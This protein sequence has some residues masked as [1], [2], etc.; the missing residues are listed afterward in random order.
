MRADLTIIQVKA[1]V[2]HFGDAFE[3]DERALLDAIEGE[4]DA[5][6]LVSKVLRQCEADLGTAAIIGDQIAERQARKKRFVERAE[7]ARETI[8]AVMDAA[9][10]T[11]IELP[12]ATITSRTL[13][14][15]LE[16]NELVGV[17][18]Q[19]TVIKRVPDK[20]AIDATFSVTDEAL[21][22]WLSVVPPRP[23]IM[24]RRS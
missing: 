3:D 11:K 13:L 1:L 20:K 16:V 9:G 12:E 8:A 6:E 14:A 15:K 7:R 4:T 17:P 21:P 24:V 22:N 10:V 2:N 19:F 18:D 23:S 5:F